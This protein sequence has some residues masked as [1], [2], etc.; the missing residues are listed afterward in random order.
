MELRAISYFRNRGASAQALRV[1]AANARD[2]FG[3]YPFSR[4]DIV[5]HKSGRAIIA[6]AAEEEKDEI[7]LNLVNHQYEFDHVRDFFDYG[8]AWDAKEQFPKFWH[9][10]ERRF[11]N[12]TVDPRVSFGRPSVESYGIETDT[13]HSAWLGAEG[14][15]HAVAN[16][17]EVPN[18]IVEEAIKF[19][20]ELPN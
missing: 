19:Q 4:R 6:A 5:F 8:V 7:L 12:V 13:L 14:D 3:E 10:D 9:P 1:A 17:F 20:R 11:P 2:A 16:W 15:Y 18:E